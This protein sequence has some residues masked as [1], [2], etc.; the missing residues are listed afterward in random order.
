MTNQSNGTMATQ[1]TERGAQYVTIR[2]GGQLFG[3]PIGRVEDVFVP[4][5]FTHV[6]LAGR[7]VAGVLNLRGRI[8]TAIDLS[9]VMGVPALNDT[10]ALRP[11]VNVQYLTESYGLLTDTVGEVIS[12]DADCLGPNPVNLNKDWARISLGTAMLE[13]ELMV[14]L[15]VDALIQDILGRELGPGTG[16]GAVLANQNTGGVAAQAMASAGE[17]A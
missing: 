2:L 15:D 17:S 1:G 8:V 10:Q 13:N 7:A 4:D 6:P 14:V 11:A 5:N 3:L 16:S 9:E 12:L